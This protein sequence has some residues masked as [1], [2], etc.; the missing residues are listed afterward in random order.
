MRALIKEVRR[1]E[2]VDGHETLWEKSNSKFEGELV[3]DVPKLF[4]LVKKKRF[5]ELVLVAHDVMVAAKSST[6]NDMDVA[7]Y[8]HLM[9]RSGCEL[10]PETV[11]PPHFQTHATGRGYP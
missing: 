8:S 7:M 6:G 11:L 1:V 10:G 5:N 2:K 4:K 9:T 3:T